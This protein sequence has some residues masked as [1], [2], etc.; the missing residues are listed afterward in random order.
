M[1]RLAGVTDA[2]SSRSVSRQIGASAGDVWALVAD[3]TQMGKWSPETTGCDWVGDAEGPSAG[4]RFKGRNAHGKKT[5]T[6]ACTVT[7]CEPGSVFAFDVKAGGMKISRW[8]YRFED[9]DGGCLVSESWT[10]RRG[11]LARTLGGMVSGVRDRAPHNE[12]TMQ[13][14]L[15]RVAAEAETAT[16]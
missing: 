7:G 5:W 4:A 10:D 6:T 3:V 2:D 1:S 16:P 12:A 13:E 9:S 11:W 8:E 14:T 15:V